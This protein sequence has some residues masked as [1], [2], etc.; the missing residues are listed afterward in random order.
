MCTVAIICEYNPFHNGHKYQVDKIRELLGEDTDIVAIMSGNFTQ[1]G[2]IAIADKL[3]RARCA[4]DAGVNLVLELPFPFSMSSAEFYARAG[5]EIANRIGVVDY[6]CFGSES[7]DIEALEAYARLSLS[8]VYKSTLNRLESDDATKSVGYAKLCEL[9]AS[10][11]MP[12]RKAIS[13][14]PNNILAIEYIKA[15]I[16]LDSLIEPITL[17]RLGAD[18]NESAIVEGELQS[19]SAIRGELLKDADSALDFVPYATKSAVLEAIDKGEMPTDS[20][21]LDTAII[22]HLRLNSPEADREIHDAK[23]GLY[24]R[25][26]A[27][28]IK[29]N[30]IQTLI[31]LTETKKYTKARIKRVIWYS[32]FGVTSSEFEARPLY[33][34]ALA[35]DERGRA[36]LKKIGKRSDFPILTKPSRLDG[37]SEDARRQKAMADRADS[38]FQL[39]KPTPADGGYALKF[40]PY[41]KRG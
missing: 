30:D 36:I 41:V 12:N 28:S 6:L 26:G 20:T 15:L 37:L 10:E 18:F 11:L 3:L 40:T 38:V 23:G 19:A 35:M 22:S 34:Q 14:T 17:K 1:R 27:A 39:T 31:A 7:G 21:R 29:A 24:N 2:D 16:L 9:A 32:Y 25:L 4:T 8:D 5:V 33:T 13:F